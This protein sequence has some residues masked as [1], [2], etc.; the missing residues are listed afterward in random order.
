MLLNELPSSRPDAALSWFPRMTANGSIAT[1]RSITPF[2]S[3]PYPTRS[4]STSS[5]SHSDAGADA[6]TVSSASMFAWMSDRIRYR[7]Q[8]SPPVDLFQDPLGDVLRPPP[9]R[10]D[11]QPCVGVRRLAHG[12]Q[13][14]HL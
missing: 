7:T 14:L 1:M 9:P 11:A 12:K 3:P 8:S 13:A 4:P 6:S 2:G 10:V 5:R